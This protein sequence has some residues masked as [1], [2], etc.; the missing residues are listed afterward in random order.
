MTT[1]IITLPLTQPET[2]TEFDYVLSS[3]AQ[4]IIRL[5]LIHI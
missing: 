1:L 3:D 4:T 5:S 2:G